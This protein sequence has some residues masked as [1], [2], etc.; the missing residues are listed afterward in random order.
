MSGLI[1]ED[2]MLRVTQ[3]GLAALD[4]VISRIDSKGILLEASDGTAMGHDIQYYFDIPNTPVP[5][6]QALAMMCVT[7][8]IQGEWY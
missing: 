1:E 5:Y 6:G 7:E 8:L 3:S 4:A 2:K